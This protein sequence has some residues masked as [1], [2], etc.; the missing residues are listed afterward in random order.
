MIVAGYLGLALVVGV[1]AALL[2]VFA[3]RASSRTRLLLRCLR[4]GLATGAVTGALFGAA[5]PLVGSAIAPVP[6]MVGGLLMLWR[7]RTS[8]TG[9]WMEVGAG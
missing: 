5:L 7:A 8:I 2:V 1:S 4:W 9:L 6:L 3:S